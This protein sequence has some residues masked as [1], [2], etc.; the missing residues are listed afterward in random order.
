MARNELGEMSA[1]RVFVDAVEIGCNR[2]RRTGSAVIPVDHRPVEI[3]PMTPQAPR[4][5]TYAQANWIKLRNRPL[6]S[7]VR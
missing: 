6:S 4:D 3:T 1:A 7:S 5:L 2:A